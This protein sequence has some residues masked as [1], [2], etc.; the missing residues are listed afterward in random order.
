LAVAHIVSKSSIANPKVYE[1]GFLRL[2]ITSC[3]MM[4]IDTVLGDNH[5]YI[6]DLPKLQTRATSKP[7]PFE[8]D[9]ISHLHALSTPL[10]FQESI[11]GLYDYSKVKVHLVTSAPGVCSGVKAEKHGLLRLRRV[12]RDIDFKLPNESEKFQLEVC[13]AS[14]GNLNAKWLHGFYDC[15]VGKETIGEASEG[16]SVPA[17]K[18]F[19]PSVGDVK[20]ADPSA[21]DAASNIGKGQSI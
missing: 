19:Y 13:A 17:L 8:S 12:L 1:I 21:Q 2:I 14:I 20:N 7:S 18:L 15:A 11:I 10:E 16:S 6:H 9:L 5:W 3:N 4:D